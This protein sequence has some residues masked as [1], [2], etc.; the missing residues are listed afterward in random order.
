MEA[1]SQQ[2]TRYDKMKTEDKSGSE[3]RCWRTSTLR[4]SDTKDVAL[5]CTTLHYVALRT[6]KGCSAVGS[7]KSKVPASARAKALQSEDQF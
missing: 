6:F 5:R 7:D 1:V 3:T 4:F 2:M